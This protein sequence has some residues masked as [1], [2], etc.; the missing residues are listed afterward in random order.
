MVCCNQGLS[1][2]E[3]LHRIAA[4]L[5]HRRDIRPGNALFQLRVPFVLVSLVQFLFFAERFVGVVIVIIL[6]FV[7]FSQILVIFGLYGR[8]RPDSSISSRKLISAQLS[9]FVRNNLNFLRFI[10]IILP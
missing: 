10:P 7:N 8:R 3:Q 6:A 9:S 4:N 1:E 2:A 5:Q